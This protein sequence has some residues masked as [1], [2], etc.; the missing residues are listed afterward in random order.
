MKRFWL[1]IVL[2][3]AIS[4]RTAQVIKPARHAYEYQPEYTIIYV[5][6]GD[7]DYLYHTPNGSA[8]QSDEHAMKE[9]LQTARRAKHGQVFIF[10][11]NAEHKILWLFPKKDREFFYFRG[12]KLVHKQRYSPHSNLKSF[13]TEAKLYQKYARNPN[14]SNAPVIFLYIGHEVPVTFNYPYDLSRPKA[15]FD[16]NTFVQGVKSFL[17]GKGSSFSL[18]VISTC[19]NGTPA[20]VQ[21]LSSYTHYILASPENLHLSQINTERLSSFLENGNTVLQTADS[22][23]A[24]TFKRLK[25]FLQTTITLSLYDTHE[26]KKYL[27]VLAKKYETYLQTLASENLLKDNIDCADLPFFHISEKNNGVKVWYKSSPFGRKAKA[28]SSFSGWGCKS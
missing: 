20:M 16:T 4:C 26:T 5:V 8:R 14:S 15:R 19:N 11:Q 1:I 17:S 24:H 28:D 3:A 7:S 25:G 9:A 10:H 27:P 23:A 6:H 2:L 21:K 12:G 18:V 13:V 22:M